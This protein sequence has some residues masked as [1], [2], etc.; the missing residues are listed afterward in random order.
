MKSLSLSKYLYIILFF[1]FN[2]NLLAEEPIDIWKKKQSSNENQKTLKLET[3]EKVNSNTIFENNKKNK[4]TSLIEASEKVEV[5]KGLYG[6]FDPA[7]NGLDLNIWSNTNGNEIKNIFSRINKIKLSSSAESL[8]TDIIMTRAYSPQNNISEKDFLNLKIEWLIKNRK[9][10]L[11]EEFLNKNENFPNKKKV[12]Q[13]LVDNNIAKANL[14]NGCKKAE[15]I[16]KEIKDAYLEKF[17]IYCLIF[18]NKKNEAQLI[19]DILKEQ[20]LSDKFFN[21]KINFLLGISKNTNKEI[22][23]DNL[24]NFYLSSITTKNFNYEPNKKTNRFIWEYLNAANLIKV[25]DI[26]DKVKINALEIAAKNNSLNKAKIFEIY[27]RKSFDINSL[28]NAEKIYQSLDGVEARA[29]I[30]QKFLLSESVESKIKLLVLLKDIFKKDGLSNIY[31]EFMSNKLKEINKND[32]PDSYMEVVARNIISEDEFKL[33]KIKYDD[34]I[35]HKSRVI[36][37][38]TE[39]DVPLK[40]TQKDLE[41]IY[42]K[43]KRSREYFFSAK[44]LVLVE[45]LE[46]DGFKIPKE[47]KYEEIAKKYNVPKTLLLLEKN[48]EIGLMALK[49]VEIIGEVEVYDLDPET[50]YFITNILDRAKLIK[51]RNRI[52]IEAL[53]SRS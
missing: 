19:F 33:G 52:I 5:V 30:Y 23:D 53:P 43:I 26:N 15:F 28:I 51:F 44:D 45:S 17:K 4:N 39:G 22:K 18:N 10:N 36:R 3:I 42:K 13:Y 49:F 21:D 48:Q 1:F 29:L 2:L 37:H 32:I 12:I 14:T 24:L 27:K 25:A 31:T 6:I 35:L 16:N 41:N 40:K 46:S 11:I 47:I 50:I 9:D 38:Y 7:E 8:F 20:N 34:K